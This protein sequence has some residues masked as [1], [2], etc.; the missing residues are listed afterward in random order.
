MEDNFLA[1]TRVKA[2]FNF[3][4]SCSKMVD[5]ANSADASFLV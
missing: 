1:E 5:S 3:D 4:Y 2:G